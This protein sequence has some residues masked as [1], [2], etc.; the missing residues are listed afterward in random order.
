MN[1]L[2]IKLQHDSGLSANGR[3]GRL[4]MLLDILIYRGHRIRHSTYYFYF[5][6]YTNSILF[7]GG[8]LLSFFI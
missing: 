4:S 5:W 1:S 8:N 7:T 3:F 2:K 6:S